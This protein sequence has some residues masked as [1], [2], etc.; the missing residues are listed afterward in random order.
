[1]SN[2]N[3]T[4]NQNNNIN[5]RPCIYNCGIQIYWNSSVKEYWEVF[6]KKKHIFPNR[7]NKS[8]GNTTITTAE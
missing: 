5:P 2:F 1:M 4:S 8:S 7:S 3:T 6:T